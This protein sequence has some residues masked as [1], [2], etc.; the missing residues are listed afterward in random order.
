M[1]KS[2]KIRWDRHVAGMD[3]K[4]D[5]YIVLVGK[6]GRKSTH[7][8]SRHNFDLREVVLKSVK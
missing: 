7:V 1:V 3:E 4:T 2:K 8:R 6:P 5:A